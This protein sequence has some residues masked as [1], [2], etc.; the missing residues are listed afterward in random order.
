MSLLKPLLNFLF[1]FILIYALLLVS[2]SEL[3]QQPYSHVFRTVAQSLF[4]SFGSKTMVHFL[5]LSETQ[6]LGINDKVDTK[7]LYSRQEVNTETGLAS[8]NYINIG[9][10]LF[11]IFY[12]GYL[13]TIL[14]IA[15]ILATPMT[16]SQ[17]GWALLWGLILVHIFILISL[18]IHLLAAI[19]QTNQLDLIVLTPIWKNILLSVHSVVVNDIGLKYIAAIFI[20]MVVV[21][22]NNQWRKLA[23]HFNLLNSSSKKKHNRHRKN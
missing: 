19:N 14:L 4:G 9:A 17:K 1:R 5:P 2:W 16:S 7:I 15:L 23:Q 10:S 13:P 21:L 11:S 20:W 18:L 6:K 3:A 8:E 22:R 12:N